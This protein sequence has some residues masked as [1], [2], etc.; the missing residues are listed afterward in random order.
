MT[1]KISLSASVILAALN[2]DTSPMMQEVL[3]LA[4]NSNSPAAVA[5]QPENIA[6]ADLKSRIV[7]FIS[8][9]R[10][11]FTSRSVNAIAEGL[12]VAPILVET[13]VQSAGDVFETRRS[14]RGLG[15][16]VELAA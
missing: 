2:G 6:G 7:D 5:A 9:S 1:N 16:L 15:T 13:T 8:A 4:A 14:T 12:G 11:R 10:D 3:S